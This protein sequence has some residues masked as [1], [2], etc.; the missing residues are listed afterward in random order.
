MDETTY[1][2]FVDMMNSLPAISV[3]KSFLRVMSVHEAV[4]LGFLMEHKQRLGL[5]SE[6]FPCSNKDVANHIDMNE[7][8]ATRYI[9]RLKKL[10]FITTRLKGLPAVRELSINVEAIKKAVKKNP[11]T[12]SR[13]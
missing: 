8:K 6:W 10:G 12:F 11:T 3:N 9:S 4:L 7:R 1:S 5:K 13:R 2:R